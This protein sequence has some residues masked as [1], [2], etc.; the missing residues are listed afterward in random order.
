[1]TLNFKQTHFMFPSADLK[2]FYLDHRREAS[3]GI[4]QRL[5]NAENNCR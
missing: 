3:M 1:M 2:Y 4:T 5:V